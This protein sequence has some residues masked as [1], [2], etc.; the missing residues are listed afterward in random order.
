MASVNRA[1]L[2]GRVGQDPEVRYLEGGAIVAKLSLATSDAYT[3]KQGE[4]V[5]NTEWHRLEL[6][7]KTAQVAEKYVRKGDQI[8]VEGKITTEKWNDKEGVE[9]YTTKIRV[10]NLTMLGSAKDKGESNGNTPANP[11][12][13]NAPFNPPAT[14]ESEDLPF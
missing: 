13:Q 14:D 3:N 6:W 7:D 2:I 1:I 9:R 10:I 11:A 8:Y 12:M 5:E 4:R